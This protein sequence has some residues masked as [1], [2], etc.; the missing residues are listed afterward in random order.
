MQ[1]PPEPGALLF[2]H[3]AFHR[4]QD[5]TYKNFCLHVADQEN[6]N[7]YWNETFMA[8]GSCWERQSFDCRIFVVSGGTVWNQDDGYRIDMT[9]GKHAFFSI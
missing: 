9:D 4:L 2:G 7:F 8:F 5:S 6:L 3:S 1:A